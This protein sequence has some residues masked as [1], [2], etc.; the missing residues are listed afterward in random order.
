MTMNHNFSMCFLF[1]SFRSKWGKRLAIA[2]LI[3][4]SILTPS[5]YYAQTQG[6]CLKAGRVLSEEELRKIV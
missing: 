5:A 3:L 1:R 6:V 4:V 2:L